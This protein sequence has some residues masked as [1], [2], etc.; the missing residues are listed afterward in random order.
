MNYPVDCSQKIDVPISVIIKLGNDSVCDIRLEA[1]FLVDAKV[2][3]SGNAGSLL[4]N[5]I[6]P[7]K[8]MNMLFNSVPEFLRQLA[9]HIEADNGN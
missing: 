8:N 3:G 1:G 6:K 4:I 5:G 7:D 9:D 2:Q